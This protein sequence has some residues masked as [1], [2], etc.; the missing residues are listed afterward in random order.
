VVPAALTIAGSDSSGGAGIQADLRVFAAFGVHG[1][2]AI[3]AVT[4]QNTRGVRAVTPLA[5]ALV[6]AQ[7]DAVLDELDVRAAKTGMLFD[8]EIVDAVAARLRQRP[9]ACVVDP[10]MVATSGA[11]LL[12]R[13][14]VATLRTVLLPLAT[15][16]TPNLH[17]AELLTGRPVRDPAG[18]RDAARALVGMGARAALVT[19]GHL[20]GPALDVL[21]DGE[22]F[23]E[24]SETRIETRSTHGTGCRL[25]AAIAAGIARGEQLHAAVTAAKRFVT[26]EL[27]SS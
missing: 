23:E 27:A 6:A 2:T 19:G 18:M 13:G 20:R 24:L 3:T 15:L 14:A 10:V 12:E 25:S 22:S 16:V 17:E 7:I 11:V 26:R 5:P 9:L 8:A 21:Y 1:A 4:A